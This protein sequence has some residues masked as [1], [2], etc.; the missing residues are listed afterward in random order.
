[1]DGAFISAAADDKV[2]FEIQVTKRWLR[3]AIVALVL[4]CRRSYL[5]IIEF[6][7][8]LLGVS[9][10]VVTLDKVVR[11]AARQADVIDRDRDLPGIRVGLHDEIF[12][13]ATRVLAGVDA[14]STYCYLLVAEQHRDV[15]T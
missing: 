7:R 6:L 14:A 13:S 2:P 1:L 10:S 9:I 4:L 15:D 11:A 5:G 3:Q 8:D 12:H